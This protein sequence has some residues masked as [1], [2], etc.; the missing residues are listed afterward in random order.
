MGIF[1]FLFGRDR[2]NQQPHPA[3]GPTTRLS[4]EEQALER[5]RYFLRTAPPDAIEQ[6]YADAFAQLTPEQRAYALREL[7][8]VLPPHERASAPQQDD[9]QTLAR[10]ATR[11]E[12]RE[13]GIVE[14]LF[15]RSEAPTAPYATPATGG[16]GFGGALA[17]TFF[18]ALIGGVLGSM[19]AQAILEGF[20][21]D[22][23]ASDLG[24]DEMS[25]GFEDFGGDLSADIGGDFI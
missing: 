14:R 22:E 10:L 2:Q 23:M 3:T 6:A 1:D 24:V 7:T 19:A 20:A 21:A 11:A 5:Y 16:M 12:L 25:T 9:P 4:S 17:G 18:G 15:S 13:P 8:N